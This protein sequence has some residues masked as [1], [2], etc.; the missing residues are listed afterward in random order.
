[1]GT[2][3]ELRPAGRETWP[4]IRARSEREQRLLADQFR[5]FPQAKLRTR[6]ALVELARLRAGNDPDRA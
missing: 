3:R 6:I 5:A 1:M 4:W 2:G